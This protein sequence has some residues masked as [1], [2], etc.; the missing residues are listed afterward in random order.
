MQE[1]E[2]LFTEI[3]K[4]FIAALFVQFFVVVFLLIS[5][6]FN[7]TNATSNNK[8]DITTL[9]YEVTVLKNNADILKADKI[10]KQDYIREMGELKE[11]LK[12]LTRKI[13]KIK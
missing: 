3:K 11:A 9:Q 13:D 12:E 1:R 6:Y 10:E 4:Q 2:N 8:E 5:F 7:T